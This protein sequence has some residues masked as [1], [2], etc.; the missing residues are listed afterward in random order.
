MVA[1]LSV[2]IRVILTL[3]SIIGGEVLKHGQ[4]NPSTGIGHGGRMT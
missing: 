2:L 1:I 3:I 4:P